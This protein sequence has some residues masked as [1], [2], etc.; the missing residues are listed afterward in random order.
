MS[1]VYVKLLRKSILIPVLLL[2]LFI[3]FILYREY[4]NTEGRN[5]AGIR[6][7]ILIINRDMGSVITSGLIKYLSRYSELVISNSDI[8]YLDYLSSIQYDYVVDIPED[9]QKHFMEGRN[10]AVNIAGTSNVEYLPIKNLLNGY[11]TAAGKILKV[12]KDI[13]PVELVKEL[14]SALG[15]ETAVILEKEDL[16]YQNNLF[17]NSYI[18]GAAY[19]LV[20]IMFFVIGRISSYYSEPGVRKRHDLAPFSA[21]NNNFKLLKDNT[22]FVVLCNLILFLIMFLLKPDIIMEWSLAV[23]FINFLIYSLCI[24]GICY[25]I[26]ALAFRYEINVILIILLTAFIALLNGDFG[27]DITDMKEMAVFSAEFTPVYWLNKVNY[28]VNNSIVSDWD[29]I[30]NIAAMLGMNALLAAAYFSVALVINKNRNE[31]I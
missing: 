7:D 12:N 29:G 15:R 19:L 17:L 27:A 1:K 22:L 5:T 6:A 11:L 14:D 28:A 26:T 24:L 8:S 30:K 25:L 20:F 21:L 13:S 9:Y 10:P 3:A 31:S 4:S 2:I 23:Y 16:R 18:K